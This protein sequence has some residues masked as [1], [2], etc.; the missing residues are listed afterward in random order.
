MYYCVFVVK[1]VHNYDAMCVYVCV[2]MCVY[3]CVCVLQAFTYNTMLQAWKVFVQLSQRLQSQVSSS[4]EQMKSMLD[5]VD[6]L[7]KNKRGAKKVLP[8]NVDRDTMII[9]V[10]CSTCSCMVSHMYNVCTRVCFD[11]VHVCFVRL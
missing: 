10:M 11:S 2:Y 5:V 9:H 4:A 6:D 7:I 3:I 1:H 8:A